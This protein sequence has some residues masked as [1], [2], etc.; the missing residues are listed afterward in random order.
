MTGNLP[1]TLK[2]FE[3]LRDLLRNEEGGDEAHLDSVAVLLEKMEQMKPAEHVYLVLV[4]W[5]EGN[6]GLIFPRPGNVPVAVTKEQGLKDFEKAKRDLVDCMVDGD[7]RENGES[8][9]GTTIRLVEL[10]RGAVLQE[11]KV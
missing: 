11:F 1:L 9:A 10:E 2:E 6:E 4:T 8:M 7:V 3:F 5:L